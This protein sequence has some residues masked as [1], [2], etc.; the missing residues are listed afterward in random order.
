MYAV[1]KIPGGFIKREGRPAE[2]AILSSRLID[3][4]LRPLF[5]KGFRNDVQVVN[6]VL[7][8]EQ[9]NA[10][11]MVAMIGAS[12]AVHISKIPFNGPIAGVTIGLIDDKYII[13][14]T[15]EQEELSEMHVSVA[16]TK[17]AVM[18]VEAGANEI[19]EDVILE[20]IMF[21]HEKIKEIVDFIEEFRAEALSLG[22]AAEKMPFEKPAPDAELEAAVREA[23]G[24]LFREAMKKASA[25]ACKRAAR[26]YVC[27]H[28]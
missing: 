25:S 2:K 12:T 1:G 10:P 3:R 18:M 13:N 6:T 20:G 26:G 8:V 17:D 23:A 22:L 7:S 11:D 15:I 27:R 28:Q 14:P 19:P 5:P 4:P 24:N 21:A 9:D 16:G